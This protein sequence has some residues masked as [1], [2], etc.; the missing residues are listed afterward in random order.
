VTIAP[1]PS[2]VSSIPGNL[3]VGFSRVYA[4]IGTLPV[5]GT[6]TA[7]PTFSLLASQDFANTTDVANFGYVPQPNQ[8]NQTLIG[9]VVIANNS[10]SAFVPGTTALD[11]G[12]GLVV[13]Y[14]DNFGVIGA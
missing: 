13:T 2:G 7:T 6:A 5:T 4:L 8:S 3:A 11:A 1:L 14:R 12:A 9:F 10:A